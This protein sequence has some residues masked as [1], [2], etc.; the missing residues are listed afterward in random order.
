MLENPVKVQK[1]VRLVVGAVVVVGLG[2]I[3]LRFSFRSMPAGGPLDVHNDKGSCTVVVDR[4]P[5]WGRAIARGDLVYYRLPGE[6][7]E[8]PFYV[9]ALAGDTLGVD[10]T[11]LVVAGV[12]LIYRTGPALESV[13]RVPEGQLVLLNHNPD[14]RLPDSC[15]AGPV[16]RDGVT[17]RILLSW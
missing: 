6:E 7:T 17:A 16:P 9:A 10:G 1:L 11:R 3:F 12:P 4:F 15:S 8:R 5:S 2:Y 14:Y 13:A